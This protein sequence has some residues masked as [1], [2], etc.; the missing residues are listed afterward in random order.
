[1]K[2]IFF[3]L[4]SLVIFP[5]QVA[6]A[7]VN[8]NIIT[9]DGITERDITNTARAIQYTGSYMY[10][11][12]QRQLHSNITLSLVKADNDLP[13]NDSGSFST[14]GN[15]TVAIK[16]SGNDYRT[17][18]LVA[19]ELIH[20]YQL[21]IVTPDTLNKNLWFTE[22][23][24]DYFAMKIAN[25]TGQDR[26]KSFLKYALQSCNYDIP[27]KDITT[28]D[29]WTFYSKTM[30]PYIIADSAILQITSKHSDETLFGYLLTLQTHTA[31]E[32]MRL[33]YGINMKQAGVSRLYRR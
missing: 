7:N 22:G 19:H 24:A 6:F 27:L 1:M 21:D 25:M 30:N 9:S 11:H 28:R 16:D 13:K 10:S 20:Q 3:L 31:D 32:A 33:I 18:F 26:T 12:F 15:I 8:V 14:Q 29:G 4:L 2:K 17:I 5:C 23:M